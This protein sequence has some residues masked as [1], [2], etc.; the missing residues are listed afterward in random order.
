MFY[1]H[2][3]GFVTGSG[4]DDL[5]GPDFLMDYNVILVTCNYRLNAL[6]FISVDTKE[7]PGNAGLKDQIA[8]LQWVKRN[9]RRFGGDPDMVTI[10]GQSAGATCVGLHL[11]SPA[12]KGLFKRAIL[13]SLSF[14]NPF[15]T[16]FAHKARAFNLGRRLNIYTSDPN[17][18]IKSLRDI[19]AEKIVATRPSILFSEEEAPDS[20]ILTTYF[21]PLVEKNLGSY[22]YLTKE[23]LDLKNQGI[24]NDADLLMGYTNAEGITNTLLLQNQILRYY[25]KYKELYVPVQISRVK[26][27]AKVLRIGDIVETYYFGNDTVTLT[28]ICKFIRYYSFAFYRF[29][30]HYYMDNLV[31]KSSSTRRYFYEF[32]LYSSRNAYSEPAAQRYGIRQAGHRDDLP[33]LFAG[34]GYN[35]TKEIDKEAREY[36]DLMCSLYT[37]FAK[38]G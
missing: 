12:A 2:G 14:F 19:P 6:G 27:S 34:P 37:N 22:H 29:G 15:S 32:A 35:L 20:P 3:G 10:F 24:Y 33:Y 5:Y 36:I 21:T 1:I 31:T 23:L 38:Y 30:I 18:L 8:A 4:N 17:E 25:P 11:L 7:V 13:M 26:S 16:P 9:I 28:N